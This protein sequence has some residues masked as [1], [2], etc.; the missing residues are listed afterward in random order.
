MAGFLTHCATAGTP[1]ETF[2]IVTT[3]DR[4]GIGDEVLLASIGLLSREAAKHSI[5]HRTAP[6]SAENYPASIASGCIL[7]VFPRS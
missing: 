7:G 1:L 3:S 4:V 2:L 6:T 5:T